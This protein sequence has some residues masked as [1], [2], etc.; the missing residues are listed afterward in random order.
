[1]DWRYPNAE[2]VEQTVRER[3]HLYPLISVEKEG[4]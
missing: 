2:F 3:E 4:R 1:M